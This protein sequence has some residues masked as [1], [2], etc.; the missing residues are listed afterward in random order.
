MSSKDSFDRSSIFA[1]RRRSSS[2]YRSNF[3]SSS[4][5]FCCL[6][7]SGHDWANR[8][9]SSASRRGPMVTH[10]QADAKGCDHDQEHEG[11]EP[12]SF[13]VVAPNVTCLRPFLARIAAGNLPQQ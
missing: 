8:A 6:R 12:K 1:I 5:L 11:A 4:V 10:R 2:R 9:W 13:H 7:N 3:F